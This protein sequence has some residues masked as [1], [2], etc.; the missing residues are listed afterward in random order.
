MCNC[1]YIRIVNSHRMARFQWQLLMHF[2]GF[3]E[4]FVAQDGYVLSVC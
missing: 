1:V 3:G 2:K 4:H